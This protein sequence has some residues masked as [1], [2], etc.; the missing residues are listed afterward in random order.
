MNEESHEAEL[1]DWLHEAR[2]VFPKLDKSVIFCDYKEMSDKKLGFVKGKVA[3][4]HDFDAEALLLGEKTTIRKKIVKPPEYGIFINSKIRKIR[5][6]LLRKQIAHTVIIHELYHVEQD[7]LVTISKEFSRRKRKKIHTHN[8][9][10]EVFDR[11]NS[12]G[13]AK[14]CQK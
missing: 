9:F 8:F 5:H 3:H 4:I 13:K 2:N 7:D 6:P 1:M 14:A 10:E 11:Y 12:S